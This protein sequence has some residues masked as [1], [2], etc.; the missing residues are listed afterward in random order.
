MKLVRNSQIW[1][2]GYLKQRA[3]RVT[4]RSKSPLKRIWVAMADHFEP[5]WL[6]PDF[7]TAQSRVDLWFSNWPK[8]A[9]NCRPDSA[10]NSPRYT[11]F[12]PEEEYDPR[13]M[14]PLAR[15]TREG[16]A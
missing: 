3:A 8:I 11:F 1:G 16:I 7:K 6:K 10:G 15:M 5:M 2:P 9:K 13:L 12:Y 14:E 4:K